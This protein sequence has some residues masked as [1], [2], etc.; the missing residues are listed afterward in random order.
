MAPRIIMASV[1][2][3][4]S[5]K[6]LAFYTQNNCSFILLCIHINLMDTI[7]SLLLLVVAQLLYIIIVYIN[8]M[9]TVYTCKYCWQQV[10]RCDYEEHIGRS[11]PDLPMECVFQCGQYIA[12]KI[13]K[14]HCQQQCNN[15]KR[16][17]S[18]QQD[19]QCI[20]TC[21]AVQ[22]TDEQ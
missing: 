20:I 16:S 13:M 3:H 7:Y 21:T 19:D 2:V 8:S 10:R 1:H 11:C 5:I 4:G 6:T 9:T 17:L 15:A 12:R 14:Q 18:Q 22:E